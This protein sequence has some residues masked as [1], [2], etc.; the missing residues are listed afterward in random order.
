[1]LKDFTLGAYY[2]DTNANAAGYTI[3]GKNIGDSQFVVYVQRVF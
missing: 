2:T 3:N 1:V